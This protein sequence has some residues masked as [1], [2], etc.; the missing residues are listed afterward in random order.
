M[1]ARHGS[2]LPQ[3][4]IVGPST[5]LRARAKVEV[6]AERRQRLVTLEDNLLQPIGHGIDSVKKP[7]DASG[8]ALDRSEE[9][10]ALNGGF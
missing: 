1:I 6:A 8:V 9:H 4:A 3:G 5:Q 2:H 10:V 7:G